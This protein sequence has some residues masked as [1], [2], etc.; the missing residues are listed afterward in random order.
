V[1]RPYSPEDDPITQSLR[2]SNEPGLSGMG[3]MRT[4]VSLHEHELADVSSAKARV[5]ISGDSGVP[6][7]GAAPQPVTKKQATT[8][9]S[10]RMDAA[11]LWVVHR[12][13]EVPPD[14]PPRCANSCGLT[15]PNRVYV[16]GSV[17][18]CCGSLGAVRAQKVT[19]CRAFGDRRGTASLA[20][21]A[22]TGRKP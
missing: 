6:S 16:V 1:T 5:A 13:N 19:L 17:N 7:P 21:Q 4:F 15:A 22:I 20:R 9:R 2:I 3:C 18:V 8:Q 10:A 11:R 14:G 12:A